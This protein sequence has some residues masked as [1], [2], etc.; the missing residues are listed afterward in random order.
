MLFEE[1]VALIASEGIAAIARGKSVEERA[2]ALANTLSATQ[3][4][5][6]SHVEK[7]QRLVGVA[8]QLFKAKIGNLTAKI[9]AGYV[10]DFVSFVENHGGVFGKDAAEVILLER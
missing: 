1:G 7:A 5:R 4:R 8:G 6:G 9:I 2:S 10:F 3:Y